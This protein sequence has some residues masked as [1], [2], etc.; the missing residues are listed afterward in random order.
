ML[1]LLYISNI[2]H[3]KLRY[4]LFSKTYT[5]E[6]IKGFIDYDGLYMLYEPIKRPSKYI[7]LL[8]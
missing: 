7:F 4:I 3:S 2:R 6:K 5:F 8:C 1:Y